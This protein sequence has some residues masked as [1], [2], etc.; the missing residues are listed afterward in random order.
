M[1]LT[2][3]LYAVMTDKF[4][5][6]SIVLPLAILNKESDL[7]I[8]VYFLAFHIS[9]SNRRKLLVQTLCLLALGGLA[10]FATHY[11][12]R[13][14]GG[15]IVQYHLVENL[16]FIS[17][18]SSYWLFYQPTAPYVFFPRGYN[19]VYLT[20]VVWLA[21]FRWTDRPTSLRRLLVWCSL[22]NIPLVLAFGQRDEIRNFSLVFA[23]LFATACWAML[24]IYGPRIAGK[25]E[26]P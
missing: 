26:G 14:F 10:L 8:I 18:V 21:L 3:S 23:P 12:A 16:Q 2:L 5:L 13:N 22:A 4:I 11:Q 1:F 24:D 7:I 25:P 9:D 19:L 17:S 15:G 20:L 6:L